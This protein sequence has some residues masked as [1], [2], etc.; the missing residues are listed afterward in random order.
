MPTVITFTTIPDRINHLAPVIDS[1]YLNQV[2]KP[3]RVVLYV[4]YNFKRTGESYVIPDY[5]NDLQSNNPWFIIRRVDEDMG[6]ITKV[7]YSFLDYNKPDDLLISIDDDIA[8]ERHFVQ[9]LLDGHRNQPNAVIGYM[10][11]LNNNFIHSEIIQFNQPQ[12]VFRKVD[13][14]GGYK[15]ILYHRKLVADDFFKIVK[16]L[17]EMHFDKF[18]RPVL[19]DD[20]LL[21]SYFKYKNIDQLVLG[22]FFPRAYYGNTIFDIVNITFLDSSKINALYSTDNTQNMYLSSSLIKDFF[23]NLKQEIPTI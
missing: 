11:T 14:L 22:T 19:E 20:N 7:F 13:L 16:D 23:T 10:G 12:R 8:Y 18:N 9:E 1:I 2:V 5:L 6:P 15:G 21:A 17:T 3:D 4:P